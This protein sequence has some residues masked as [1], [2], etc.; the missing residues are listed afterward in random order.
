[1]KHTQTR[2][3]AS[4]VIFVFFVFLLELLSSS[5]LIIFA[6][7]VVPVRIVGVVFRIVHA[8]V[9]DCDFVAVARR[10]RC[11]MPRIA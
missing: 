10:L 2:I 5:T 3:S 9:R 4:R 7:F 6:D 11:L 1:M 8:R